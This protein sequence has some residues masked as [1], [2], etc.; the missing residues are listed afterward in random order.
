MNIPNQSG[1][2]VKIDETTLTHHSHPESM[3]TLG[4][5]LG[6]V[7]S[8]VLDKHIMTCI[9]R[10]SVIQSSSITIKIRCAPRKN[11]H[12]ELVHWVAPEYLVSYFKTA[13]PVFPLHSQH[14]VDCTALKFL[15][16]V[17]FDWYIAELS[18]NPTYST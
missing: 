9:Q 2:F 13:F 4:F 16:Y 17:V 6:V 11:P 7:N 3:M 5:I 14:Y 1:M 8:M 18:V 10:C 12:F 15:R